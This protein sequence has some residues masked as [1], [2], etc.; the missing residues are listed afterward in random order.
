MNDPERV[1]G[2]VD[3]GLTHVGW[4]VVARYAAKL[5]LVDSGHIE[6]DPQWELDD[7]LRRI[8]RMLVEP[9]REYR[10]SVIGYEDQLGPVIGAQEKQLRAARTGSKKGFFNAHNHH[11]FETVG[12]VKAIAFGYRARVERVA[13]QTLKI[14][15]L[16]KGNGHAEKSEVIKGVRR[17][18]P[19]IERDGHVLVEHEADAIAG[20]IHVERTEHLRSRVRRRAG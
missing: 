9:F 18:L 15:V 4:A 10:P 17:Y 8:W 11:V 5:D 7:R 19:G 2:F 6:T 20:A 16:G 13:S 12:I 14:A 1:I 3:P